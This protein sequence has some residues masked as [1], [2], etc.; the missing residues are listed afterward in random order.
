MDVEKCAAGIKT[1]K[2]SLPQNLFLTGKPVFN[3]KSLKDAVKRF[4]VSLSNSESRY[5]ALESFLRRGFP[6]IEGIEE[7]AEILSSGRT[8]VDVVT[9]LQESYLFIQGPP[10]S[11]KTYTSSQIIVELMRLGKRIGISS[12]SHKAIN[13]LLEGVVKAAKKKDFQFRGQKKSN[14]DQ[15][16]SHFQGEMIQN[17]FKNTEL[18]LSMNLIAGTA[19]LFA[20]EE[21]D[22]VLDYLFIDEAG[23]VSL[24]NL[25]A[26]GMSAK[27]IILVGDQMQLA[28]P[29]QGTH[30]GDSGLSCLEYLLQ[31]FSVI[32]PQRG[33]FLG[34]SWRMHP[35]VCRFISEVV[36]DGKLH[37]EESN[38]N[39]SLI[40]NNHVHP[41]LK[42]S[43]VHFLPVQH[44]GCSQKSEEEGKVVSKLYE[45]LLQQSFCSRDGNVS[46]FSHENI[47][48]V[49]PYN[50][51]VNYL[52]SILLEE[53]RVGT[54]DKFQGQEAEVVIVSMVTSGAEDL[55]RDIEF[56]YSK[57]RLNVALSRARILALVVANPGLLEIP[58]T[59][60]EQMR[61]V[62][63]LCWVREYSTVS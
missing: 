42:E 30:P 33:I 5:Q 2:A 37:A 40:L 62:N 27:N 46:A 45:S 50:V 11:G 41:D 38:A 49:T 6:S 3:T 9:R 13:N 16:D 60:V 25:I 12:N 10:G 61:L 63:S 23:Q 21:M 28:Q 4:A 7:G 48:I 58:C 29:L 39:Q 8:A 32:S 54:V 35:Q 56:L 1:T 43:G 24:A 47:L 55:P 52:R 31:G 44:E 34:T 20:R 15:D 59:T 19:W 14:K 26:M 53:A 57:N 51:Q 18:D 22:R 17:F 36:Y